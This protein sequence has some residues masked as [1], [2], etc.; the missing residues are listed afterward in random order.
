[1]CG[2]GVGSELL[3][4]LASMDNLSDVRECLVAHLGTSSACMQFVKAFC[5]HWKKLA[6]GEP[7]NLP[8]RP[9][10]EQPTLQ[11]TTATSGRRRR[12]KR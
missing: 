1:L 11:N 5:D 3:A 9:V 4:F 10:V 8:A 7:L 2:G 6:N 12:R